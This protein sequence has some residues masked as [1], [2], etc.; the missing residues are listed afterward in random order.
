MTVCHAPSAC[1]EKLLRCCCA[2]LLK[3]PLLPICSLPCTHSTLFHRQALRQ[4]LLLLLLLYRLSRPRRVRLASFTGARILSPVSIAMGSALGGGEEVFH[5]V[6]GSNRALGFE[7]RATV[8]ERSWRRPRLPARLSDTHK[9]HGHIAVA[10]AFSSRHRHG[11]GTGRCRLP[12]PRGR[13]L[14]HPAVEPRVPPSAERRGRAAQDPRGAQ[15]LARSGHPSAA[16]A[17]TA[18]SKHAGRSSKRRHELGCIAYLLSFA[19][20]AQVTTLAFTLAMSS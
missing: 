4:L 9:L 7:K 11:K 3:P 17:R 2:N 14:L 13:L 1:A 20:G 18:C 19:V 12:R 16:Q 8:A 10:A 6:S 5:P 15:G